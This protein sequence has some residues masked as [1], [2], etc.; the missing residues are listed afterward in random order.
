MTTPPAPPTRLTAL[1]GAGEGPDGSARAETADLV[2][3][4]VEDPPAVTRVLHEDGWDPA[5]AQ[6]A[7]TEVCLVR[8]VL[9]APV[10]DV[11][12]GRTVRVGEV[13]LA[14]APDGTLRVVGVE[15][16]PGST[17][18]RLV[19]RRHRRRT[20]APGARLLSLHEVHL[21]SRHGHAA[22]LAAA[23]SVVHRLDEHQLAGLLTSL[24]VEMAAEVVRG[25]PRERA[26]AAI[27]HLHPRVSARL[28]RGLGTAPDEGPRRSRRTAGWRLDRPHPHGHRS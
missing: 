4:L 3:D 27:R 24:P 10:Y 18:H 15:I 25:L 5:P 6:L 20:P 17:W 2:A 9:D 8:D 13:W 28:A 26:E 7:A 16:G 19:P 14:R 23:G 22:Q 11:G 1:L 12:A 21:S